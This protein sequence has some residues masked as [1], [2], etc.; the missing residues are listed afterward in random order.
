MPF[1]G[2]SWFRLREHIRKLGWIYIVGTLSCL[3]L[4]N[5]LYTSTRPR[6]PPEQSVLVYLMDAYADTE[7]LEPLAAEALEAAQREDPL[8]EE[9]KFEW[10]QFND[11]ETDYT[12]GMLL[13]TRMALGEGDVYV[14]SSYGLESLIGSG[15]CRPLDDDLAAGWLDG[16]DLEPVPVTDAETGETFIGALKLDNVTALSELQIFNNH[17]AYLIMASN[18]TNGVASRAAVDYML[19]TLME[20]NYAPAES[21]EPTA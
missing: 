15:L 19:R 4:T 1:Q 17:G 12:S 6:I 10:L 16:L 11:P 18:S 3:M 21:T 5:L 7:R 2:L 13:M 20:G 8:L 9:V 14:T